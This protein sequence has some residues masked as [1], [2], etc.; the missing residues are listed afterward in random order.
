MPPCPIVSAPAWAPRL[1]S[2][3]ARERDAM[4]ATPRVSPFLW[5]QSRAE[6]EANFY[7]SLFL[8]SRGV[9]AVASPL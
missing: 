8:A 1:M 6:E 3:G 4:A 9:S 2:A 7:V 5:F